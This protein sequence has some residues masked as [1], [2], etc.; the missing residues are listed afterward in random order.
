MKLTATQLRRIIAEETSSVM[1]EMPTR[2]TADFYAI[3]P[4]VEAKLDE[5]NGISIDLSQ[6]RTRLRIKTL[7][8]EIVNL[9]EQLK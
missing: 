4:Q 3:A 2:G 1:S 9:L 6:T 8:Q 5:L 7:C